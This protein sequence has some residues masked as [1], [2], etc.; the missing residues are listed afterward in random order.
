MKE[1]LL[2]NNSAALKK[3]HYNKFYRVKTEA[4]AQVFFC[5]ETSLAN[6]VIFAQFQTNN[7]V[8]VSKAILF[9]HEITDY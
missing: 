6:F 9:W 5:P 3:E 8:L 4:N 2:F 7:P 1:W